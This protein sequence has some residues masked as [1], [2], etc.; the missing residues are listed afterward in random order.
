METTDDTPRTASFICKCEHC[1]GGRLVHW[2]CDSCHGGPYRF[3]HADPP[4]VPMKTPYGQRQYNDHEGKVAGI[5]RW[6]SASCALTEEKLYLMHLLDQAQARR[7]METVRII[8]GRLH[9]LSQ[10]APA[11]IST[12]PESLQ[13]PAAAPARAASL[14]DESQ[15]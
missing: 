6:C 9:E 13:R 5:R 8:S 14:A 3:S 1:I 11:V 2:R 12:V 15:E 7:D 4:G 10:T